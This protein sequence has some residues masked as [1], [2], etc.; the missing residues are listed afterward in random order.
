MR[1]SVCTAC[2]SPAAPVRRPQ[3]GG[4]I[5]SA[6]DTRSKFCAPAR[7]LSWLMIISGPGNAKTETLQ[8]TSG[9]GA[10]VV[11]T[12]TSDAALL[13]AS[14]RKQRAKGATGGL[15]RRIGERGI[16]AII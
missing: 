9:L 12:L 16:L 7:K 4:N 15:L 10:H 8:A 13:S 3:R 2:H 14:P 5:S 11:S 6:V 1:Y